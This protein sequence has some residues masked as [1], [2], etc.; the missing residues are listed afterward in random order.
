MSTATI[1]GVDPGLLTAYVALLVLAVTPIYLGA[2]QSID[3][4]SP[5]SPADPKAK[6]T[7]RS[8]TSG[9]DKEVL[10]SSD[11]YWFPI[12]GSAV[13]FGLYLLF[14]YLDK[15]HVNTLLTVYFALLGC[16]ALASVFADAVA[17]V[18]RFLGLDKYNLTLTHESQSAEQQKPKSKIA[19]LYSVKFTRLSIVTFILAAL[20]TAGY[21]LTKHWLLNN[22]FAFALSI[23]AI[24][25]MDL[26][27][28]KTGMTLLAGLF[29]YD[30]FWVFGTN[31]MVSVAKS[32]DAPVKMLFPKSA[33]Q[34]IEAL[35]KAKTGFTMLGLGDIVIP[36][37]YVALSLRFDYHNHLATKAAPIKQRVTGSKAA[38][39]LGAGLN[40]VLTTSFA[41]PYFTTCFLA[42]VSGLVATV[43]VMHT[44]QAAQPALLYLSPACILSTLLTALVRG[45]LGAMFAYSSEVDKDLKDELVA[46]APA[47]ATS[48]TK[49]HKKPAA[50]VA[51]SSSS[52]SSSSEA[53]SDEDEPI[54]Q[55]DRKRA[56]KLAPSAPIA[57]TAAPVAATTTGAP[58]KK[59]T[60]KPVTASAAATK[61]TSAS[62]AAAAAAAAADAAAKEA[63][64]KRKRRD[65][66]R[67]REASATGNTSSDDQATHTHA[68]KSKASK[69]AAKKAAAAATA[70]AAPALVSGVFTE[71]IARRALARLACLSTQRARSKSPVS[72]DVFTT[73]DLQASI[74][75]SLVDDEFMVVSRKGK[76]GGKAGNKAAAAG[77]EG[78][79][80]PSP[81]VYDRESSA[82]PAPKKDAKP[83][84]SNFKLADPSDFGL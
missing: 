83:D 61:D 20:L 36:G 68:K 54:I 40:D 13:L 41:T 22:L 17:P 55:Q 59:P 70:T 52:S 32:F 71:A 10:S 74:S 84:Y 50:A 33:A 27:S 3:L 8:D 60:A 65:A 58:K 4:L 69:A 63:E 28:F 45:E 26:D 12:T 25:L 5:P 34:G 77:G 18:E 16:Y 73:A 42:Y 14:N 75:A 64:R 30:V 53:E 35:I 80:S 49:K 19:Q 56:R 47:K 24:A 11:A 76:K 23:T 79:A 29:V 39:V 46:A 2:N 48:A 44:Y 9:L 31:V 7:R 82:S 6:P 57:A 37:I 67:T 62:A 72:R 51:V 38:A 1:L 15:D 43:W 21:V 78:E 66:E 81:D